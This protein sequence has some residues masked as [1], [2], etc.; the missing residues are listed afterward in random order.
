M[1]PPARKPKG[2]PRT[3]SNP[4]PAAPGARPPEDPAAPEQPIAPKEPAAPAPKE[5]QEPQAPEE[6]ERPTRPRPPTRPQRPPRPERPSRPQGEQTAEADL[7]DFGSSPDVSLCDWSNLNVTQL[8]WQPSQGQ[9]A[10]WLG[11]P[12]EDVSYGD[13]LGGY[14]VFETSQ[15]SRRRRSA[16]ATSSRRC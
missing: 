8:Q 7:C 6:P 1:N 12:Q 5:P 2:R 9:S 3:A 16:E 15:R 11:G 4:K 10:F 14:A 13:D